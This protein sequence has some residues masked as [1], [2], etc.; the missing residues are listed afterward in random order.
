MR[1]E[2]SSDS[3]SALD[4]NGEIRRIVREESAKFLAIPRTFLTEREAEQLMR[5]APKT[6]GVRRSQGKPVPP[7]YGQGRLRRYKTDEVIAW[8]EAGSGV[9]A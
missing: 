2:A 7:S 5:W 8:V 9:A 6:L 4:P 3:Y 1:A